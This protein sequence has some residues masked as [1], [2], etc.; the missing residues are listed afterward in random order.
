MQLLTE[1]RGW[2]T[3]ICVDS[4]DNEMQCT[5]NNRKL[6]SFNSQYF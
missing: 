2:I 6:F 5:Y 1:S 3:V 4:A